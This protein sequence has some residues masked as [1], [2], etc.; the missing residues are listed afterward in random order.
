MIE[1][2][3]T[4]VLIVDDHAHA[5]EAIREQLSEY[6]D[7][8]I[9]GEARS[10]EEAIFLSD[11]LHPDLI[12]MDINMPDLDGLKTTKLIKERHPN[13]K[14][15]ILTVSEDSTH[16]FEA[17]KQGAQ[18]FLIKKVNPGDWYPY[19]KSVV[20]DNIP[21]SYELVNEVIQTISSHPRKSSTHTHPANPLSQREMEILKLVAKGYTNK[22][23]S[24][25]IFISEYTVKNHLKNITK[26]LDIKNRVHLTRY[27][28][29]NGWV[30]Q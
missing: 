8:T 5:R 20:S 2:K 1:T 3:I 25:M 26:K 17:L 15:V 9:I 7:F 30:E 6:E 11:Q 29:E 22:E 14:I 4:K 23:I 28:I 21:V 24:N 16:L 27:A 13:I 19:L 12:L 18:G 10:G